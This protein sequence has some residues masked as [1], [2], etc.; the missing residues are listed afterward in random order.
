MIK[1]IMWGALA[2]AVA[3]SHSTLAEAQSAGEPPPTFSASDLLGAGRVTGP[4]YRVARTVRNDGF[5][6]HY[7][8]TVDRKTYAVVG[9]AMM[10]AR[11]RELA[12]LRRMDAIKRTSVYAKAL[13]TAALSPLRVAKDLV[14]KP[15]STVTG[16]VK[17][18]A[19]GIGSIFSGVGQTLFG[20]RSKHEEGLLK[21]VGG[22]NI[23]KRKF[24]YRF[25][26]DPYTTFPPV[27]DR[28]SEISW[29]AVAGNLTVTAAFS[30][31]S[32]GAAVV[33]KG[34]KVS[35]AVR[36]LLR[37]KSPTDLKEINARRLKRMGVGDRIAGLFLTHPKFL[38]S[39]ATGLVDALS[40]VRASNRVVF[41]ERA[42]LVQNETMAFLMWRWAEMFAAYHT[43]IA[44]IKRFA[45]LGRMPVAQRADGV[46]IIAVPIDHIAW[47]AAIAS[48]HGT[49]MR[50]IT[51]ISNVTGGEVWIEG[52]ISPKA[53]KALEAQNWVVRDNTR[54][55]L[56]LE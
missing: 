11:L 43:R 56:G 24:A 3:T 10:R 33:I 16:T 18:I 52:S 7:A 22:Y 26:I 21:T 5:L 25:G 39:V 30:A 50:S 20:G 37:D 6:N 17:G 36:A 13:K 42:I 27:R 49:N 1:R 45:R 44:P 53:R 2:L 28:L 14:T 4:N 31:V 46:L 8:V 54:S 15:I 32:G 34:T 23:A 12:A 29:A 51:G 48:R 41:I 19:S 47:T 35:G 38:P 55:K 9:N 40:R